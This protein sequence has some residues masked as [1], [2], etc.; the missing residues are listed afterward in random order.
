MLRSTRL[1]L[2]LA[3]LAAATTV[4]AASPAPTPPMGWNSWDAYAFTLDEAQFRANAAVVKGLKGLGWTY[5][6]IDEGWYMRNPLGDKLATRDYLLDGHGLLVPDPKRFP[7]AADGQGF[8]ALADWTH[9]QG[10]KFGIHIVRGIPKQ[11]VHDNAP[12]AGSAFHAADAADEAAT[13]P[14]DDANFGVKDNAAGQAYYDSMIAMYAAWGL[15]FLKVDCISDH[16]Y[17]LSEIR[18]IAEAIRKSGRPIV[19]SLSPG[20]TQV[21]HADEVA[22]YAEMWRISD[23]T[24][25]GWAFE[26]TDPTSEFPNGVLHGFEALAKWSPYVREG[27]WPDADMLPFGSLRPHAGWGDPR[28]SRLTPDEER[29][30]FT[31]WA[32]ARSPLILGG[33][34]TEPDPFVRTLITNRDVIALDQRAGSGRPVERLPSGL[35][36][37]RVWVSTPK[38]AKRPDTVAVF[39]LD[40]RP[41]SVDAAWAD[42]GLPDG[43]HAARDLWGGVP[44]KR[45]SRARFSVPAHGVALYR[46]D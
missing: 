6:V 16:P 4:K 43:P 35:E 13:C 34:L 42:L 25:D 24:W 9:A 17:R 26:H 39:N 29:T 10:L 2:V 14:W 8:K 20:P 36:Q 38:G 22:R 18:Q 31:L 19:L 3:A 40:S 37:A 44:L 41:L 11:A 27:H 15:D 21:S 5:V 23:D 7:S 28:P 1:A 30:Q 33:N 32:I 46:V 12:V 45:S